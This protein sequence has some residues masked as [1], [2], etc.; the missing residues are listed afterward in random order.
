MVHDCGGL[1]NNPVLQLQMGW[2]VSSCAGLRA[3]EQR[4]EEV[5]GNE[6]PRS[7]AMDIGCIQ[8]MIHEAIL[9]CLSGHLELFPLFPKVEASEALYECR[10]F[11]GVYMHFRS[12]VSQISQLSSISFNAVWIFISVSAEWSTG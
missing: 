10:L 6:C 11:F 4:R 3:K 12:L 2:V 5:T 8:V 9:S 1:Y 7:L